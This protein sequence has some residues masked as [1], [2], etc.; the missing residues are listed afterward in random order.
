MNRSNCLDIEKMVESLVKGA[1]LELYLTPKPGLVDLA[2]CGSHAD[3]SLSSMELSI[4]SIADYLLELYRSLS[5]EERFEH[6]VAIAKRAERNMHTTLG[7]NTHKGYLFLSGLFLIAL[8][9]T[10][11]RDEHSLRATI[12]SL[13]NDFFTTRGESGTNGQQARTRFRAGGI[14]REATCGF[15]S[16]FNA[17][18]PAFR[19]SV[20]RIGCLKTASFAMLARLMQTVEDTTTLHRSGLFGLFRIRRDGQALERVLVEGGDHISF[21]NNLNQLYIRKSITMGGVADMLALSYGYLIFRGEISLTNEVSCINNGINY[22]LE[23]MSPLI[24][25]RPASSAWFGQPLTS[26]LLYEVPSG[27]LR[28]DALFEALQSVCCPSW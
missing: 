10:R 25:T 23:E 18:L 17:A 2:D 14:V 13:A 28:R 19:A 6:Q 5:A 4:H 12:S 11:S 7:T 27:S 15:P 20:T 21:L 26:G 24:H 22:Y 9:H 16:L 1:A 8:W 3:L